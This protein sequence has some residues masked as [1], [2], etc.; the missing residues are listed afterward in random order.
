MKAAERQLRIRQMFETRDF[1]DLE[2]LCRELE[3]SESSVRRDLD[4]LEE[5][6]AIMTP[7]ADA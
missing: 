7:K 5:E 2:T 3:A 6:K 1:L 4:I